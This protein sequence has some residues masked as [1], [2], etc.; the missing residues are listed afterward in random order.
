MAYFERTGETTFR[1]T[2][3]VSGAWNTAEQHIAPAL[4]LLAHAVELDHDARR[5]DLVIGRLSYD[6]LGKLPVEEVE[7]EVNLTR[8]GRTIELVEAVLEH[9]GRP[10]V[11]LRAWLMQPNDSPDLQA[12]PLASIPPPEAMPAWS[13]TTVWPGGFIA[14]VEVRRAQAEPGRA[15]FWVRTP[16]PLIRDEQVSQVA[17]TAGLL[18][19]ANGMTVRVSPREVAFPN[20]DLTAHLFTEPRGDWVGFDTSVTFGPSGIGLTTSVLHDAH[21]PIGTSSQILSIRPLLRS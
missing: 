6:I 1:P 18:D 2:E 17:S 4:G 20:L 14:S 13:P 21:G 19:I 5:G 10:A 3:H 8:P 12:T 15:A 16:L 9:R 11:L 7:V